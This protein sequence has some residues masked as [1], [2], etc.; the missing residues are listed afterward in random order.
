MASG[1]QLVSRIKQ[2]RSLIQGM[3][4][5]GR[6]NQPGGFNAPL[7]PVAAD[8]AGRKF[9]LA[10]KKM[11][12]LGEN[13]I[14]SLLPRAE[15]S[16][17]TDILSKFK[18]IE[19]VIHIN[20]KTVRDGSI[21][22]EVETTLPGGAQP[23]QQ[24]AR[25][26]PNTLQQGSV[27]QKFKTVPDP[28]QSIESFRKQ[29]ESQP[30]PSR[31]SVARKKK[32]TISPGDRLFSRVQEIN[33]AKQETGIDIPGASV[34][35][36]KSV[37]QKPPKVDA[38]KV[39][40]QP[41][42]E[43]KAVS[44]ATVQRQIDLPVVIKQAIKIKEEPDRKQ[45]EEV[46]ES[47]SF[48][49]APVE[50]DLPE[51]EVLSSTQ[52]L[53]P[54]SAMQEPAPISVT[55]VRPVQKA[56]PVEKKPAIKKALPV[57][58]DKGEGKQPLV[59]KAR[60]VVSPT[61]QREEVAVVQRKSSPLPKSTP[62]KPAAT[63]R[64]SKPT[65]AEGVAKV[66]KAQSRRDEAVPPGAAL[67]VKADAHAMQVVPQKQDVQ[68]EPAAEDAA[69]SIETGVSEFVQEETSYQEMPLRQALVERRKA[70]ER[71]IRRAV[72]V[73]LKQGQ[74]PILTHIADPMIASQK[75]R[76][77]VV[78]GTMEDREFFILYINRTE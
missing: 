70:A 63:V 69:S 14:S 22:S 3:L 78:S 75:P 40:N 31:P 28:G 76:S 56:L 17:S 48:T 7:S 66:E 30:R 35:P 38:P 9:Q 73:K 64:V 18:D 62:V 43:P 60:P 20:P 74:R 57:K 54:V 29:I 36:E 51:V 26:D 44:P 77:K 61:I 71:T 59:K 49:E 15:M 47:T 50:E 42:A 33:P 1:S 16:L 5:P 67:P 21:W 11:R 23:V 68:V 8:F 27:I 34:E 55:E 19:K 39:V 37:E 52:E 53:P 65:S 46:D 32:A 10:A 13:N 6:K 12:V 41:T 45:L 72:P 24:T 25:P 58:K 4:S 2:Q